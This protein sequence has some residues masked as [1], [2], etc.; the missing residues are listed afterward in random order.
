MKKNP[1][2]I[3]SV[4]GDVLAGIYFRMKEFQKTAPETAKDDSRAFCD[5]GNG[6]EELKG[7]KNV[8]S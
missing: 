2:L 4:V 7:A 3:G 5:V 1:V 6:W 8:R